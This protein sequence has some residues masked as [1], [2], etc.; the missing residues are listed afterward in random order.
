MIAKDGLDKVSW[1]SIAKAVNYSP[2]GLYEYF[3]NKDEIVKSLAEEGMGLLNKALSATEAHLSFESKLIVLGEAYIAFSQEHYDYFHLMFSVLPSKRD[4]LEQTPAGPYK[5]LLDIVEQ[6]I[7][8]AVLK[9][10]EGF[11]AEAITYSFWSLIHG[12]ASLRSSTLR[13]FKAQ[14]EQTNQEAMKR[15]I[16]GLKT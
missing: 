5:R 16:Q 11:D 13:D 1:R 9:E 2:S 3:A 6:G 4:S 14:F 7:D 8:E 15:F 10:T 12:M